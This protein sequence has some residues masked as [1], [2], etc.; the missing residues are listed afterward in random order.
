MLNSNDY[1]SILHKPTRK[2]DTC[3]T[4][5]DHAYTNDVNCKIVS[6]ILKYQISDHFPIFVCIQSLK[7]TLEKPAGRLCCCMCNFVPSNYCNSL[8]VTLEDLFND[9]TELSTSNFD[10]FFQQ[11]LIIIQS[12]VDAHAPLR[13][14]S[15]K[16]KKM[17]RKSWISKGI[18]VSIKKSRNCIKL[19]IYMIAPRKNCITKDTITS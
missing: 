17:R 13:R 1:F 18:L 3:A 7:K 12:V 9:F 6:R 15:R 16:Q 5:T 10:S 4:L 2:S 11:F 8:Q 19:I 14:F